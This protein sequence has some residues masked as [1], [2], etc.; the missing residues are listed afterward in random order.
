MKIIGRKERANFPELNLRNVKVKVD[1]G[2]YTSSIHC[3]S[4]L[5]GENN[6]VSCVFLE[7]G[8]K[9]YTGE[10]CTFD[11]V[12]E[13]VVKSSNGTGEQR[14]MIRTTIELLGEEYPIYLTLTN[15]NDMRYPVLLGRRFLSGKFLIDVSLKSRSKKG[16]S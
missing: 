12:K 15:R 11:V 4:I 16:K 13:V 9:G 6:K 8:E 2:A 7:P 1:S 5:T 3:S 10:V 14:C